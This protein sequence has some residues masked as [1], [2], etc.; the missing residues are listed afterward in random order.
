MDRRIKE[1][2]DLTK[3][4]FGLDNYYLKQHS[5]YRNVNIFNKTIYTLCM[6]WFPNHIIEQED[7]ESNP[8]GAAVIE[9]NL[10]T[11]KF[12][13]VIFVMGKT[14]AKDGIT[15]AN[16]NLNNMINWIEYETGLT[17]G[18]QFQLDKQ[19]EGAFR[20]RECID[21]VAVSP[22]GYIE[23][24]VN[25]EGDLTLYR[26]SGQF[27]SKEMV[28]EEAYTLTLDMIEHLAKEQLQ[29]VEFPSYD[30]EKMIPVYAVEEIY[31]ENDGMLT[32]PFEFITDVRSYLKIDKI[33]NWNES[34]NVPFERKE[35]GWIEDVTT[36]QA[37]SAEPSPDT[38]PITKAE[39]DRCVMTVK[40]LLR[41]EYPNDT[42]KW[43]LKTLHR[44]KGYIHATL[45]AK[46]QENRVFQRKIKVMIDA[47]SFQ[48]VNYIDNKS[49]LEMFEEFQV[50]DNGMITKEEAYEKIKELFELKPYYVYEFKQN[51]YILCG[52]LD[53]QYG[54][55]A[56]NGEVIALADL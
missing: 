45:R 7:D 14:Y 6:E 3:K 23:V 25:Q 35:I 40:D 27:P 13:R 1:L 43:I 38:F 12:E 29:L 2:V 22:S 47:N 28:K 24:N 10:H 48:A 17:Y 9:I 53:C 52:K 56:S 37:F 16:L 11:R 44:D 55:N 26:V 51:Q 34:I 49:M 5:F 30:Q 21:G 31:V 4:K 32:I 46:R 50:P 18:K 20:F 42:G 36:E 8:E 39:E 54:V 33:M 19:E 41:Q 15:F